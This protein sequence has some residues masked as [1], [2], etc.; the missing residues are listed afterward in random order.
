MANLNERICPFCG[1]G[2][3][4]FD[5]DEG[6]CSVC[7]IRRRVGIVEGRIFDELKAAPSAARR[8]FGSFHGRTGKLQQRPPRPTRAKCGERYEA[9]LEEWELRI[10]LMDY[11]TARARLKQLRKISRRYGGEL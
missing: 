1:R 8:S 3:R 4:S 6:I 11:E 7:H 2:R 9:E 5:E 10:A